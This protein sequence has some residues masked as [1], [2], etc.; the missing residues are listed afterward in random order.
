MAL[1]GM[2]QP[3]RALDECIRILKPGGKLVITEPT[4]KLDVEVIIKGAQASLK[5]KGLLES[6]ARPW[7]LVQEAG[8]WLKETIHFR[9]E[10][11]EAQLAKNRFSVQQKISSHF[12]QCTT[13]VATKPRRSNPGAYQAI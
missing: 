13:I 5:K 12:G 11:V 2:E 8:R 9:I 7:Q 4:S 10:D 6:L 1:Y 3:S